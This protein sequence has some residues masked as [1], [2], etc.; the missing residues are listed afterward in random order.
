MVDEQEGFGAAACHDA[1]VEPATHMCHATGQVDAASGATGADVQGRNPAVVGP[2]LEHH[3][4]ERR[5]VDVGIGV[6]RFAEDDLGAQAPVV[7]HHEHEVG[8]CGNGEERRPPGEH[9][10]GRSHTHVHGIPS[11]GT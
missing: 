2:A 4:L 11:R 6:E 9:D 3:R 10:H 7:G 1:V 5:V 8:P